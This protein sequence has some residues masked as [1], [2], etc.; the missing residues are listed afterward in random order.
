METE[1]RELDEMLRVHK[2]VALVAKRVKLAAELQKVD[3]ELGRESRTDDP[4]YDP[5]V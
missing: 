2:I 1:D 5:S 3:A 4:D